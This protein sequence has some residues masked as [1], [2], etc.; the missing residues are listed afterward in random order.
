MMKNQMSFKY[1]NQRVNINNPKCYFF[2]LYLLF[3][4][5]QHIQ[6]FLLV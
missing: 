3:L 5:L 6:S 2:I 4:L 1:D